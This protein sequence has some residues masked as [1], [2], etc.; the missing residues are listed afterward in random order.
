MTQH[1]RKV[2]TFRI[3]SHLLDNRFVRT[4]LKMCSCCILEG[5]WQW[6]ETAAEV[7][8]KRCWAVV[9]MW[10][11]SETSG[12]LERQPLY[13]KRL[14]KPRVLEQTQENSA[15]FWKALE[16]DLNFLTVTCCGCGMRPICK[17]K[18]INCL[19]DKVHETVLQSAVLHWVQNKIKQVWMKGVFTGNER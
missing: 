5:T 8:Q 16:S 7:A 1:Y 12:V 17:S 10:P 6:L 4:A 11:L 9:C 15:T 3:F 2:I 18:E 13:L 19:D 14:G